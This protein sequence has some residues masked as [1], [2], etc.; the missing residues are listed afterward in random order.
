MRLFGL[1]G[2]LLVLGFKEVYCRSTMAIKTPASVLLLFLAQGQFVTSVSAECCALKTV[3]NY[4]YTLTTWEGAIPDEC[5]DSC[6]YTRDGYGESLYCFA[7]G[8][9]NVV[10]LCNPCSE[11]NG[12]ETRCENTPTC[13]YDTVNEVCSPKDDDMQHSSTSPITPNDI[14]PQCTLIAT[15]IVTLHATCDDDLLVFADGEVI[16]DNKGDWGKSHSLNVPI[17][18]RVLGLMCKDTGGAYGIVASTDTG[19]FTNESW[20]CSSENITGWTQP[21]FKDEDNKF[22]AAKSG[23]QYDANPDVA[24]VPQGIDNEAKSI[25][26]PTPGGFAFCRMPLCANDT[27]ENPGTLVFEK[28][29]EF[30][31]TRNNKLGEVDFLGEEYTITFQLLPDCW[32]T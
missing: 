8:Y 19:V 15:D 2:L 9:L 28:K 12:E 7:P 21:G 24:S 13:F 26:G 31:L 25:W 20:V 22:S 5:K 4:S 17:G 23:T 6:A 10:C 30:I 11:C 16:G 18:T 32:N 29:Q 27:Q 3:G 14:L 1:F